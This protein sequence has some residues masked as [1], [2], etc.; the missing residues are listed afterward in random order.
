VGATF[1]DYRPSPHLGSRTENVVLALGDSHTFGVF[2]PEEASYP[3]QLQQELDRRTPSKYRVVNLGLPGTSSAEI[4][5]RLPAWIDEYRPRAVIVCV[6][7]NNNWNHAGTRKH[8][9]DQAVS[10]FRVVRLFRLIRLN[11]RARNQELPPRPLVNRELVGNGEGGVIYRNRETREV[12]VHHQGNLR[13]PA[14]TLEQARELLGQDLE[15]IRNLTVDAGVELVLLTYGATPIGDRQRFWRTDTMSSKMVE[16]GRAHDVTVVDVR[17]RFEALLSDGRPRTA[18]FHSE[19]EGHEN[20]AGY[21]EIAR[22]VADAFEP[23]PTNSGSL[24]ALEETSAT[25]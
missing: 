1:F 2:Y 6:G 3:A 9:H 12:L 18:L 24:T 10:S 7:V 22:L 19:T 25:P 16:F 23:L 11:W 21:A 15:I 14:F 20:P 13:N 4:V 17:P 5:D 8:A